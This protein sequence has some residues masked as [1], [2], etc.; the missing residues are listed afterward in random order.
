MI[1]LSWQLSTVIINFP[2]VRTSHIFR[3]RRTNSVLASQVQKKCNECK[4]SVCR[5]F[6]T[7][8]NLE[9]RNLYE[10]TSTKHVNSDSIINKII[11]VDPEKLKV[12]KNCRK[13]FNKNNNEKIWVDFM[14]LK[15][16]SSIIQLITIHS[17][18]K[19]ISR[20][21]RVVKNLSIN[22]YNFCRKYLVSSLAN[23]ANLG[24]IISEHN[25]G[26]LCNC[27]ETQLQIFKNCKLALDRYEEW[28]HN[29][30]ISICNHLKTKLTNDLLQ[31]YADINGYVNPATSDITKLNVTRRDQ[32]YYHIPNLF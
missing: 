1:Q 2:S 4:L 28:R 17:I 23:R 21:Q 13:I 32:N 5:I 25:I 6:K 22:L 31:L 27:P 14:Q 29:S 11:I 8:P 24:W 26:E 12:K 10:V 7:S 9:V 30:E 19:E 16:Q 20:W 18:S 3:G 15:K